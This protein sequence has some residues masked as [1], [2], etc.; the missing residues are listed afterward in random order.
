LLAKRLLRLIYLLL[1]FSGISKPEQF[2]NVLN[3]GKVP[4]RNYPEVIIKNKKDAQFG[5]DMYRLLKSSKIVLNNHGEI[6]GGYAGNMRMFEATGVGSCLLTDNKDNLGDLFDVG[7]EIMVYDSPEDCAEKIQWLLE[8]EEE[9]ER[10]ALAGQQKTL[11]FHTVQN[12][13]RQIIDI[14]K[15]EINPTQPSPNRQV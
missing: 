5:L 6:A 8:H 9:R 7:C 1:K 3:Y 15:S 11:N 10:I 14:I 2:I 13:C 4:L 12:R